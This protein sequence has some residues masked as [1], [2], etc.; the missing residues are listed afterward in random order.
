MK[1]ITIVLALFLLVGLVGAFA[2]DSFSYDISKFPVTRNATAFT[3]Q[4]DDFFIPLP[5][6]SEDLTRYRNVIIRAKSFDADG[7]L[8]T[9]GH[10]KAMATILVDSSLVATNMDAPAIRQDGH[11]NHIWKGF[12]ISNRDNLPGSDAVSSN[13]GAP[14]MIR[15]KANPTGILLQNLNADVKFIEI[16]EI[17]FLR[18]R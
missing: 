3:K 5:E 10:N 8:I 16:E 2:Q 6:V 1:K 9:R 18:P 15:G 12:N 4:Y 17:T 7:N 11:S 14:A 13:R